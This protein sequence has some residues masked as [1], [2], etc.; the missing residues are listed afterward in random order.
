MWIK[1][2]FALVKR[3]VEPKAVEAKISF[4]LIFAGSTLHRAPR[5]NDGLINDHPRGTQ[6]NYL[7]GGR[8]GRN[9]IWV[10]APRLSR[11]RAANE[12]SIASGVNRNVRSMTPM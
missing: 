6:K 2:A 4:S 12:A 9:M 10:A 8:S 7:A 1:R 11:F 5:S 3:V